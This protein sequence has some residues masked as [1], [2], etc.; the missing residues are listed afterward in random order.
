[1]NRQVILLRSI[2]ENNTITQRGLVKTTGIA[3]GSVNTLIKKCMTDSLIEHGCREKGETYRVS[4]K[5]M[6]F[7]K[8]YMVDGAVIMAAGFGSRFVPLTFETPKGLLEV[9]GEPMVER[10]IKQLN[11]VGITDIAVIVGYM[12]EKFEYLTD[13]YGCTLIYNKD[14]ETKN[15]ISSIYAARDFIRGRN[16]YI[17]SSDNWI[18]DNM[19]HSY[20]G[21]AWYS[22]VHF[23]G[24]TSEW[25]LVTD[26]KG[27][28]TDTYP[29]GRDCNCMMGPAYFSRDFSDSF[30]PVLERYAKMP[31][32]DDYY[33]ENVLMDMLNGTAKKRLNAFFG[34]I[35]ELELCSSL[36]MSIN[37]QPDNN[38]YEFENLEELRSFD[39]KYIDD[40]GSEAMQLVSRVFNA[41]ESKI[42]NIRRLKAGMTN[43]SWLFSLEGSSYICRIPG[44]GTEKLINRH[45]EKAVYDAVKYLDITERLIYYDENSGYKISEY[46]ENSRNADSHNDTDMAYCMKKLKMLHDSNISVAHRFDIAAKI[47]F[48]EELCGGID[49]IPFSDY[50]VI[51]EIKERLLNWLSGLKHKEVLSHIDPVADNFIFLEG[52]DISENER[53]QSKIK[54]I[55]WEYAAMND[56]LIDIGM[57]AIY[58][59]MEEDSTEKL[60][61]AY[62]GREPEK[63]ERLTVYAYMALGGLLW[64]LWG[65]YKEQLGVSFSDYTIK[66]Y[67]YFKKYSEK[68]LKEA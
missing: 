43:N 28:I 56:P 57:C 55:D 10:Q 17:L 19:Y 30:M 14:Y 32:T 67:R 31:G 63:E 22:G 23:D 62:F 1:M 49:N 64:S 38:V 2:L 68:V 40:S 3:L 27:R 44:Q 50:G 5:G 35:P 26:K 45:E 4:E 25:V 39:K 47:K 59:Y 51:S 24:S 42:T 20:E 52:A 6:E 54:L 16:I 58:S 46:Y 21:G 60:M 41:P 18:R 48:Y 11:S 61:N 8:P 9:F 29:G 37:L 34:H 33:W 36:N 53:D 66:M 7:I 15:N 65:V 12:K 13:K